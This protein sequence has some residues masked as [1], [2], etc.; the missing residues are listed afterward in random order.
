MAI[1]SSL[2]RLRNLTIFFVNGEL[3]FDEQ[4]QTLKEFYIGAPTGNV[5][6]DFPAMEGIRMSVD[7]FCEI[8]SFL[9]KYCSKRPKGKTALVFSID[10]DF[11]LSKTGE[12]DVNIEESPWKIKAFRSMAKA[13]IWIEEEQ[14]DEPSNFLGNPDSILKDPNR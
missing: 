10:I 8:I 4:I 6:W 9:K 13:L 1:H 12:T 14:P 5:L 7:E 11:S 3:T 2:D